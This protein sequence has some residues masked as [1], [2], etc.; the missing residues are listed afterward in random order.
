MA[1][2]PIHAYTYT[3]IIVVSKRLGVTLSVHV[4]MSLRLD[5][6]DDALLRGVRSDIRDIA[7]AAPMT[8]AHAGDG[9]TASAARTLYSGYREAAGF[10]EICMEQCHCTLTSRAANPCHIVTMSQGFGC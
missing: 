5:W 10:E 4:A 8:C 9:R 3:F 6:T 2:T 1:H 7:E